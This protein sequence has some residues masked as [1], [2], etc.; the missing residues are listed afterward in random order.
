M[1][2]LL[3]D[4]ITWYI[5]HSNVYRVVTHKTFEGNHITK[6]LN[7]CIFIGVKSDVFD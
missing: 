2:E 5:D 1:I 7:G 4:E 3:S 6:P